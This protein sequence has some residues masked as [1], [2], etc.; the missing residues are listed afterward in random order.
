M[1]SIPSAFPEL[2]FCCCLCGPPP[3][4]PDPTEVLPGQTPMPKLT[5]KPLWY[6][7]EEPYERRCSYDAC[8]DIFPQECGQ[9]Q[10]AWAGST[11]LHDP[12]AAR[13]Q[14]TPKMV[15]RR[16]HDVMTQ[17]QAWMGLLLR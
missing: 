9:G 16:C 2:N 6:Y 5:T 13:G 17:A 11:G 1:S 3:E 14:L 10:T 15:V 12:F 7:Y 8:G 4:G